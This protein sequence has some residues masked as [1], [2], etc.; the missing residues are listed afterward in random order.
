MAH[1]SSPW[2]EWKQGHN[3]YRRTPFQ[4]L[5]L[6]ATLKGRGPIRNA[7][8][9]RRQRIQNTPERFPLF[10]AVLDLA[11]V[12]E[13]EERILDPET[14]LYAELC[15]HRSRV[16]SIDLKDVPSRLAEITPPI[17]DPQCVRDVQRLT[18][19]VPPLR[20]RTFPT[21]IES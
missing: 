14:R 16:V 5:G 1:S 19:F 12:N 20:V 2:E 4:I 10:G 13:A 9:Q 17:P 21:L 15:T 3:P 6:S 8:R 18:R 7:I 11:E